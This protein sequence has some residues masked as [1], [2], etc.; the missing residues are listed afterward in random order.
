M[1]GSDFDGE[2]A[3]A[4]AMATRLLKI[5]NLTWADLVIRAMPPA[6]R[7]APPPPPPHCWYEGVKTEEEW[8]TAIREHRWDYLS[9]W[10]RSFL[11]S[12]L[13]RDRWPLSDKQR[14]V[15]DKLRSRYVPYA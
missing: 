4:A 8:C 11:D 12:V 2:R 1:L 5:N 6:P 3:S 7:A 13:R 14:G 9:E 15:L 10:E